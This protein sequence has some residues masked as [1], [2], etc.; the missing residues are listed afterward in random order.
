[1][2][3][4]VDP[5]FADIGD[6]TPKEIAAI[7]LMA[8]YG[9]TSGCSTTP[10]NYC[11]DLSVTRG[12][13]AV[14][15]VRSIY[16][17]NN[18][19]YNPTPYFTDVPTNYLFFKYIQ[20]MKE[21]GITSGCTATTYCPD[22]TVT[23]GQMAVFIIR[24][25]YGTGVAFN[26]TPT[27]YFD[28]VPLGALFFQ[29]IQKMKDVGVTSGCTATTY[30]PSEAVTRGEMAL[31]LMR[32][33]F[34]QLL[35]PAA[36]VVTAVSPVTGTA[37]TTVTVTITGLNTNFV[38]DTSV[39]TAGAGITVQ[40]VTVNSSTSL[41]AQ[42]V[43]AAN[44]TI[45]PRSIV[46]STGAEEAVAPNGFTITSDPAAGAIA[47]WTGNNTTTNAVSGM[48]GSLVNGATYASATSRTKGVPDAQA[49]SLDGATSYVQAAAGETA[50]LSGARTLVAWVY[51]NASTGL[52]MPIL[53]ASDI[54][55]I[56]GTTGTCSGGGQYQLYID[57]GG[58]CYVSNISLCAECMVARGG[59]VRRHERG[60]L[61]QRRGL[62]ARC[63]RRCSAMDSR[64]MRSAAI[65]SAGH[66]RA[67][68]S[69]AC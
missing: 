66:R 60:V 61:Y 47:Y 2:T 53:T 40:S 35:P 50:T 57:H 36:P 51:P 32:G 12:Q 54:F 25:R 17:S 31:F 24:A 43:I 67:P 4:T 23:R 42:L 33:S 41:T 44:A 55:G 62:G 30:C 10:F 21:L 16:G 59:D 3:F 64:P 49:F 65:R 14:F 69:T 39:V 48:D 52:G 34:N 22:D 27:P 18:F 8:S 11:G 68:R 58:T 56:T 45:G 13:M 6:Q 26:Y 19:T 7:N 63:P 5:A 37:G 9:I 1:M 15:I 38:Q 28:D 46:V 29:Y 20:K